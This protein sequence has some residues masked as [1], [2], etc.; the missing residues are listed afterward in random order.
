MVA[1]INQLPP[2]T[3]PPPTKEDLDYVDLVNLDLSQF[4]DPAGRKQLAKDLYEAATGYGFLTLTNHGI[5]DETYQR[6]MRIANAAMTL[7]PEDK[8][9]YE[10]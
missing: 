10:G 4:D 5:S 3:P 2:Y 9:P 7:R 8:A 1:D 6:Q